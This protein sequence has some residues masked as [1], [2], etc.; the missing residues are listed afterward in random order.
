LDVRTGSSPHGQQEIILEEEIKM[1]EENI[2]ERLKKYA[3][4]LESQKSMISKE[5]YES[6]GVMWGD[7]DE[8]A[9]NAY[10]K[11]RERFYQL[12]PEIKG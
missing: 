12:F 10:S 11:S 6:L 8:G 9:C 7:E 1:E 5:N 2:I 4:F 3:S